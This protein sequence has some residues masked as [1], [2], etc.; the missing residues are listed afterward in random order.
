[1]MSVTYCAFSSFLAM[2]ILKSCEVNVKEGKENGYVSFM[3]FV[4]D[5]FS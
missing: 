5:Q 3:A 2:A 4:H 1:M